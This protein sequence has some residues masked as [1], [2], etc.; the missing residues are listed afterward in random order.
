[1]SEE[2]KEL[3]VEEAPA[4][5]KKKDKPF[6][7]FDYVTIPIKEYRKMIRKIERLEAE[8]KA[9]EK[10]TEIQKRADDYRRWWK[11]EEK[12]KEE[13]RKNYDTLKGMYEELLGLSELDKVK[14]AEMQFEKGVTDD[15]V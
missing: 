3:A 12:E 1:M 2:L 14:L 9:F 8:A 5:K 6:R 4:K 15:T 10:V 13:L 11:D 7:P